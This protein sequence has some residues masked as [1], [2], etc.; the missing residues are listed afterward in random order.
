MQQMK[1]LFYLKVGGGIPAILALPLFYPPMLFFLVRG[2]FG[3]QLKRLMYLSLGVTAGNVAI[4]L[5]L[6]KSVNR[7]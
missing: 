7:R 4:A 6:N 3:K 5:N 2:Y 1:T